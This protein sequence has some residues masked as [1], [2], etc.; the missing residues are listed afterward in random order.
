MTSYDK[1]YSQS[2][3]NLVKC[4]EIYNDTKKLK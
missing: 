3:Q 4:K 1:R 2:T